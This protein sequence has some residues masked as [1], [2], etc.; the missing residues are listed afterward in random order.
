[1]SCQNCVNHVNEALSKLNEVTKVNVNLD[2]IYA[3]LEANSDVDYKDINFAMKMQ[4]M[5]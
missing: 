3:E 4:D 5:K 1:M 2:G